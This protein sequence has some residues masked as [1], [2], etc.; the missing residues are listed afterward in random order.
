MWSLPDIKH[1][2]EAAQARADKERALTD[3]QRDRLCEKEL[4]DN[5]CKY[6]GGVP[7]LA[8]KR[9][10]VFSDDPKGVFYACEKC[11]DNYMDEGFFYC[12]VCERRMI[13]NYTW[14]VYYVFREE[15]VS[16]L[17]L[18]CYLDQEIDNPDNWL[19]SPDDVTW[20]RIRASKH[21]IPVAGTHWQDR[22]GVIYNVPFFKMFGG[23]G[24]RGCF[25]SG[26]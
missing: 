19:T 4:R 16:M 13:E 21:L 17:C 8:E 15:G 7:D 22:V 25:F 26:I 6:C 14:E 24:G 9:Y 5:G 2:N 12:D 23:T 20:E 1:L 11:R 3:K 18:N 10:D